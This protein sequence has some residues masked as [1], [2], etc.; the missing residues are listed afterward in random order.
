MP[1]G[2]SQHTRFLVQVCGAARLPGFFLLH[3]SVTQLYVF[4]GDEK[5]PVTARF[6]QKWLRQVAH[7]V[8]KNEA[9][10]A[11]VSDT[12]IAPY[13]SGEGEDRADDCSS[14]RSRSWGQ[15]MQFKSHLGLL[16]GIWRY[17]T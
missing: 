1:K 10:A 6:A 3:D 13:R 11:S 2:T 8:E 9:Q 16:Y 7:D 4:V 12:S 15:L 14:V 17:L 5:R